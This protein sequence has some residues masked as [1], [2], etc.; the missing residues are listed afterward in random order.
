ME[1]CS[2][3]R[4]SDSAGT[5]EEYEIVESVVPDPHQ[6]QPTLYHPLQPQHQHQEPQLNIANNGNMEDLQLELKEVKST[7]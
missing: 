1:E 2:S 7:L 4:S 5:S 3:L 6:L